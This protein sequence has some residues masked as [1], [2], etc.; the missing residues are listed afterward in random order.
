ML[1]SWQ[2]PACSQ[3]SGTSPSSGR[4]YSHFSPKGFTQPRLGTFV[5]V[6]T[7]GLLAEK[8]WDSDVAMH[9]TAPRVPP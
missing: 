8:R 1:W 2:E 7:G 9:P 3:T 4:R 5:V 6:T